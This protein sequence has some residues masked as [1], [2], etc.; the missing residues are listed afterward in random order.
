M[1]NVIGGCGV[2]LRLATGEKLLV[3]SQC[4][5]ELTTTI[6]QDKNETGTRCRLV[7]LKICTWE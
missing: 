3:G 6:V 4:P 2:E 1:H 7:P 5:K